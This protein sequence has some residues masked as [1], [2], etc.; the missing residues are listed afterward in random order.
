[1]T[2]L[3]LG[4]RKSHMEQNHVNRELLQNRD[5]PPEKELPEAQHYSSSE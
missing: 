2:L 3:S 4:K 5:I 1:M